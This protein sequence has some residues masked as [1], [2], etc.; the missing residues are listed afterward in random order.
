MLLFQMSYLI[1]LTTTKSKLSAGLDNAM[2]NWEN[3]FVL[4]DL[5]EVTL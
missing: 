3:M 1:A 4:C 2:G 5:D